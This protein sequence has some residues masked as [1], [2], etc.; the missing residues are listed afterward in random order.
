M[1]AISA[2]KGSQI[3]AAVDLSQIM[4]VIN[5]QSFKF[6]KLISNEH[7]KL[8]LSREN[9]LVFFSHSYEFISLF[10]LQYKTIK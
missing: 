2:V 8:R 6:G 4:A 3:N 10:S 9:F 5:T 1:W 7:F